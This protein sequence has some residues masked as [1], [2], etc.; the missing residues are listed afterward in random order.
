MSKLNLMQK[1]VYYYID[2]TRVFTK[3]CENDQICSFRNDYLD[4]QEGYFPSPVGLSVSL[5]VSLSVW[6][7]GWRAADGTVLYPGMIPS[8]SPC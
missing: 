6:L 1:Y 8:N 7:A 2:K 3:M 5:Y 4:S